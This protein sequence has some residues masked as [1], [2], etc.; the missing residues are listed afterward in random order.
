M[1]SLVFD[2]MVALCYAACWFVFVLRVRRQF[3]GWVFD[4]HIFVINILVLY[5]YST[6]HMTEN[7]SL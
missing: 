5:Y 2:E 3:W 4:E 1:T 7:V 6:I